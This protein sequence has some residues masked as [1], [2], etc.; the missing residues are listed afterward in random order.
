[1]KNKLQCLLKCIYHFSKYAWT[2]LI[3]NKGSITVRNAIAQVFI[4]CYPE[5]ILSDN[6]KEFINKIL[7]AYLEE[8]EVKHYYGEQYHAQ[9][10]GVIE[11]FNRTVPSYL[12]VA[13]D[14]AKDEKMN[15]DLQMNLLHFLHFYNFKSKHTIIDQISKRVLDN[16]NNEKVR[17]KAITTFI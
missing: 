15:W 2:I 13:Y 1:M 6:E 17:K 4:Q 12:S 16:F 5:L 11:A 3:R 14:N 8:I 9:S 7:N 10:Q